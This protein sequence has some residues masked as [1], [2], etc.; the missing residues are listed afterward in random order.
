MRT[1]NDRDAFM[2]WGRRKL[3]P[4]PYWDKLAD[5]TWLE[6]NYNVFVQRMDVRK[7]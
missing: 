4:G 6:R 5:G 1:L 2:F 3:S 7:T